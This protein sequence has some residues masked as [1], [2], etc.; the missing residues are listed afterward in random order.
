MIFHKKIIAILSTKIKF[1]LVLFIILSLITGTFDAFSISYFAKIFEQNSQGFGA[2]GSMHGVYGFALLTIISYVLKI[3]LLW[4]SI[5]LSFKITTLL[6]TYLMTNAMDLANSKSSVSQSLDDITRVTEFVATSYIFGTLKLISGI[7]VCAVVFS[8]LWVNSDG[9]AT[10]MLMALTGAYIV[11]AGVLKGTFGIHADVIKNYSSKTL[12]LGK[13]ILESRETIVASNL[14]KQSIKQWSEYDRKLKSILTYGQFFANS[15]RLFIELFGLIMICVFIFYQMD[16][17]S[18]LF[19]EIALLI[20]VAQRILPIIQQCYAS[21]SARRIA[22]AQYLA[23]IDRLSDYQEGEWTSYLRKGEIK[24]IDINIQGQSDP[25]N[26]KLKLGDDLKIVGPSGSGKTTV[27]RA[28]IGIL[29]ST[30]IEAFV[31]G[32]RDC[33][34]LG[35]VGYVSQSAQLFHGSLEENVFIFGHPDMENSEKIFETCN[36]DAVRQRLR[37]Q[38]IDPNGTQLSGGEIRRVMIARVLAMEKTILAFDEAFT[39]L[40]K[41]TASDIVAKLQK[42][43]PEKIKIFIEHS[44]ILDDLNCKILDVQDIRM[45]P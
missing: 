45:I 17:I 18:E 2:S 16:T 21:L 9:S 33:D 36:L 28:M 25:I 13:S 7:I 14:E 12:S 34:L 22:S 35:K 39:G 32:D 1:Y 4:L 5:S 23:I 3:I 15:P 27:L 42:S 11:L 43:Y 38:S 31:N 44:D 20:V 8:S 40:D 6:N 26:L 29:Q 19:A 37:N 24:Y 10:F 30:N 41:R